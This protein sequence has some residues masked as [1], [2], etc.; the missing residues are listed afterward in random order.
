MAPRLFKNSDL[1]FAAANLG[2]TIKSV[3]K[4]Q[5]KNEHICNGA[6]GNVLSLHLH[7]AL[8]LLKVI[9]S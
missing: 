8:I 4:I 7:S 1:V 5:P 9:K 2:L 6:F 3:N